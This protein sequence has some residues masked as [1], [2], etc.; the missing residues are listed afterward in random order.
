MYFVTLVPGTQ[1][2][3][4]ISKY[5]GIAPVFNLDSANTVNFANFK[6]GFF[7]FVGRVFQF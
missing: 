6:S 4:S 7:Y 5:S 2:F 3:S 1:E